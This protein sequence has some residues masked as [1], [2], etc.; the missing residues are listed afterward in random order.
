M[1]A[2]WTM[3]LTAGS[4]ALVLADQGWAQFTPTFQSRELTALACA[5]HRGENDAD[6]ASAT[7]EDMGDLDVGLHVTA[8]VGTASAQQRTHQFSRITASCVT[9]SGGSFGEAATDDDLAFADASGGSDCDFHFS[10]AEPTPFTLVGHAAVGGAPFGGTGE[11][12]FAGAGREI[13]FIQVNN[14]HRQDQFLVSGVLDPGNYSFEAHLFTLASAAGRESA[15]EATATFW[16]ELRAG[17]F[18]DEAFE[19]SFDLDQDASVFDVT[20]QFPGEEPQ[21][22]TVH[23][24]G[25]ILAL[26]TTGCAG[27]D[28]LEIENMDL[29]TV[30]DGFVI[31]VPGGGK[32]LLENVS[33]G[34]GKRGGPGP[35]EREGGG[36]FAGTLPEY[37][38]IV[39]GEW[40]PAP[41]GVPPPFAAIW[42]AC[43]AALVTDDRD[44]GPAGAALG[45]PGIDF[46][47]E[48]D[49]GLG[50][51]NPTMTIT[52]SIAA[53]E[54]AGC[55]ADL[56]GSGD[57]GFN[58]LVAVL[59]SW[60]PVDPCP[61]SV[62]EDI[63]G[64]C[65]VGFEDLVL[66]LSAWGPCP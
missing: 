53:L 64:D 35:L 31:D 48:M 24:D 44:P 39:S 37:E 55:P 26:L 3:M 30:E 13:A 46:T 21:Q 45:F 47:T 43:Y 32:V 25:E 41:R 9:V 10:V 23:L 1:T 50:E 40:T 18:E 2:K 5:E 16:M 4:L 27:P 58:D 8:A 11:L 49:L 57:V 51:G 33:V 7:A 63:D 42:L 65:V 66:V 29:R 28:S 38:I 36:P 20:V 54:A 62:P 56:D 34:L 60:G 61:P 17:S 19:V 59:S 15:E 22:F 52:G 14:G 12:R 6:E